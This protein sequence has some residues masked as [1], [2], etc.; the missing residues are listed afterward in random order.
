MATVS[1]LDYL[2]FALEALCCAFD[3]LL[4]PASLVN[5]TYP[6]VGSGG[7]YTP[8]SMAHANRMGC[9]CNSVMYRWER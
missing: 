2:K 7:C 8:P 3:Y 9:D 5:Y 4:T 6:K 1:D